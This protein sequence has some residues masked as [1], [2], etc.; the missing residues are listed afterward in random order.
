MA[1]RLQMAT[2]YSRENI[3]D[4]LICYAYMDEIL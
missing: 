2:I 4:L 3:K 1:L